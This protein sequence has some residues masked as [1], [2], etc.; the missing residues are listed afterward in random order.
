VC[1]DGG[2]VRP[3]DPSAPK[4]SVRNLR[5]WGR[6]V[7]SVA[8]VVLIVCGTL[9]GRAL[10]SGSTPKSVVILAP[11][12]VLVAGQSLRSPD[13]A[14]TAKMQSDGNFVIYMTSSDRVIWATATSGHKDA[15]A[16]LEDG[17]FY[18]YPHGVS[19]PPSL[20]LWS[21]PSSGGSGASLEVQNNGELVFKSRDGHLKAV[22]Q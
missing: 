9:L 18:V 17:V 2:T 8:L 16:V 3:P 7:G 20:N 21:S 5:R 1:L 12:Q 11:G 4:R 13:G 15:Y 19:G 6:A 10:L 14:Y 22:N